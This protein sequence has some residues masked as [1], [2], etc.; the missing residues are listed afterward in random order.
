MTTARDNLRDDTAAGVRTCA[1]A[2]VHACVHF[3]R[4]SAQ[5]KEGEV[6]LSYA[7]VKLSNDKSLEKIGKL[8]ISVNRNKFS[9][10]SIQ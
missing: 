10:V 4:C 2:C 8:N 7:L 9:K 3:L 1:L 5:G 6:K